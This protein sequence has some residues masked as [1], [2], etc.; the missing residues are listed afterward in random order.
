MALVIARKCGQRV[1]IGE[2]TVEVV[3]I[4]N[5]AVRLAISAPPSVK[6]VR[7]EI[8]HKEKKKHE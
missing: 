5:N 8:K 2:V 1:E 4:S 3:R 7:S 6:I